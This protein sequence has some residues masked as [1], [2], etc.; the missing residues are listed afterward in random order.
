MLEA[1]KTHFPSVFPFIS[2]AYKEPSNLYINGNHLRSSRGIQQGDPLGPALFALTIHPIVKSLGTELNLWFIDD[3]TIA[4]TADVVLASLDH[5][6][7]ESDRV[8]LSLNLKKCEFATI[9]PDASDRAAVME[10]F[11]DY[12]PDIRCMPD[13]DTT[14]LGAPL[15]ETSI[16]TILNLKT[17]QFKTLSERLSTISAHSA[18]FLLRLSISTPRLI[19]FLRCSPSWHDENGL[20]LYDEALKAILEAIL[21]VS[22]TEDAW[23]QSAL[24]VK[25][26]GL[27][28]RHASDC[29][30]PC[31]LSSFHASEDLINK[32]LPCEDHFLDKNFIEGV[33]IWSK[34]NVPLPEFLD[35]QRQ[36][37]WEVPLIKKSFEVLLE[38]SESHEDR[39]RLI[40]ASSEHAGDWLNTLPSS[41]IGT[42]LQDDCFRV[43]VALRLGCGICVPHRCP[44]GEFVTESGRHGLKCK[45]SAGRFPRHTELNDIIC[46]A[47][48]LAQVPS[49][50]EPQGCARAD[51]K[52][53]DGLTMVP[54]Q[55]GKCLVWDVTCTDTFAPS[56]LPFTCA[57]SGAA[58]EL[59]EERKRKKYAFL[60]DR[61]IFKTGC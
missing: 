57:R 29:A 13:N 47:L 17:N 1:V 12:S 31:F 3:G 44:C 24:P 56:Y 8:G 19:Y 11:H 26:G 52:R 23:K 22:L 37:S 6:I 39:A 14:L 5:I 50:K 38:K 18:F 15:T 59:A 51:G 10:K 45:K 25:L 46:R 54:W 48:Q 41:A 33:E 35:T 20:A 60:E 53:P 28:I 7:K 49:R 9:S 43:S 34:E 61:Y 30:V 40:A 42:H 21:N 58:A 4:D 32:L 27:G 36:S 55:R 16:S 2:Q